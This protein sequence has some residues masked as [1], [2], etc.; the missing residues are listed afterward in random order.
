[1]VGGPCWG[2]ELAVVDK[3]LVSMKSCLAAGACTG[4][5]YRSGEYSY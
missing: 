4:L 3:D 1:M 2:I 5:N